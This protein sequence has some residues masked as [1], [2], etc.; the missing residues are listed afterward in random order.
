MPSIKIEYLSDN[1]DCEMCGSSWASGAKVFL[2]GEEILSLEPIA[3]CY[4][5]SNWDRDDVY[6]ELIKKLGYTVEDESARNIEEE[7]DNG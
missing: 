5:G 3:H 7:D 2:D 6:Y 4:A 1:I